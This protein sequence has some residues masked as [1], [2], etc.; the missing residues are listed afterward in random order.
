MILFNPK[1]DCK[2]QKVI[3]DKDGRF[4][5]TDI[6]IEDSH[7]IVVNLYAPND[8]NQQITFFQKL[9]ELLKDFAG[10]PMIIGGDFNCALKP[11]DKKGGQD[12][13]IKTLVIKKI[14]HMCHIFGLKDIW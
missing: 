14:E 3:S 1:L 11:I 13:S 10:E 9:C 8:I 2:I 7:L 12:T 4:I 5:I 6:V